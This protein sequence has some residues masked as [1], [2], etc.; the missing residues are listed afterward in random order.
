[1]AGCELV[2]RGKPGKAGDEDRSSDRRA[3]HLIVP[4]KAPGGAAHI[5][6]PAA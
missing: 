3:G 1:M 6:S 5:L 2:G 4:V